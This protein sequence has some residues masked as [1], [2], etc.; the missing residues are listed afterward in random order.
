MP[1][2][3]RTSARQHAVRE[4]AAE[5]LALRAAAGD[6]EG[7]RDADHE[8]ER[9]LD[10]VPRH[11]A[12]PR[13]VIEQVGELSR[14]AAR[15]GIVVRLTAMFMISDAMNSIVTPRNASSGRQSN[16]RARTDAALSLALRRGAASVI[17]PGC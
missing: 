10:Q 2:A 1:S 6:R 14:H 3:T 16:G 17:A 5:G 4:H 12:N 9:R 8:H 13:H 7:Q 11:A 15:S